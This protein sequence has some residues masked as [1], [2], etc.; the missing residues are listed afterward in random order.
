V[1]KL[2]DNQDVEQPKVDYSVG[3]GKP[4]LHSRFKAG[5]SGNPRGRPR[6]TKN[7][8]TILNQTLN[9]RVLVTDNGK[10]KSITKQ[11]AIF[12]QLVNKAA[13]GDHRAAQLLLSEIREVENRIGSTP[14]G[15]EII[16]EIDQQV[17]QNL[18]KRLGRQADENDNGNDSNHE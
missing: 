11:E 16:D 3:Y 6:G 9:E 7:R 1:K 15:R 5:Q 18:L 14:S 8:I 2:A 12:K 10:R 17:V 4:P 13:S